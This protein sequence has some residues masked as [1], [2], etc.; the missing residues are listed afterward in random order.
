M[1]DFSSKKDFVLKNFCKNIVTWKQLTEKSK[2]NED[3]MAIFMLPEPIIREYKKPG[4][5]DDEIIKMQFPAMAMLKLPNGQQI[6]ILVRF[7]ENGKPVF[8]G[9]SEDIMKLFVEECKP[10]ESNGN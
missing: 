9:V 8:G 4:S 3:K 10:E 1:I 5:N 6:S 7:D 2:G